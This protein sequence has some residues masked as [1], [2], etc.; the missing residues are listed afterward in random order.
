MN[1]KIKKTLPELLIEDG[2]AY[3]PTG[4]TG[5]EKDRNPLRSFSCEDV[6]KNIKIFCE[7]KIG[8]ELVLAKMQKH[9]E[10]SVKARTCD[11]GSVFQKEKEKQEGV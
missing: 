11:C 10:K 6:L 9:L 3:P 1:K 5:K 8:D 2:E 7:G 4:P